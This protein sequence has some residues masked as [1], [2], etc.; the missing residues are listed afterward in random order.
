M[1]IKA[2]VQPSYWRARAAAM[3]ALIPCMAHAE[4]KAIM[5]K[6]AADFDN[7]ADRTDIA[8]KRPKRSRSSKQRQALLR[9]ESGGAPLRG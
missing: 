1:P 3:R 2:D 8:S 5:A 4:S 9:R 6:L 7:R